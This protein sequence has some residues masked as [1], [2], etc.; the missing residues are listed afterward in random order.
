MAFIV[1]D[2]TGLTN[3]TSYTSV[4]EADA[5]FAIDE[6][7][8]ATW[9]AFTT[10][11]KENLLQQAT[12]HLDLVFDYEGNKAFTSASLR[13][14]RTQV[15]DLEGNAVSSSSV[16]LA[17]KYATCEMAL[18]FS[19]TDFSADPSDKGIKELVVDVIEIKFDK[20]DRR[21]AAPD[22][23]R[24]WL[25]GYGRLAVTGRIVNLVVG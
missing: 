22:R 11:K 15:V 6:L 25:R 7:N 9:A 10:G 17:I 23:V 16:P 18:A 14:P 12:R 3:A 21:G 13:W 20:G 2:G 19:S 24:N 1:E 4:A 5:Y 8:S